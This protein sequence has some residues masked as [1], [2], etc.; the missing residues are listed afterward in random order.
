MYVSKYKKYK[1]KYLSLRK[2]QNQ[3]GGNKNFIVTINIKNNLHVKNVYTTDYQCETN[4]NLSMTEFYDAIKN[5][6]ISENIDAIDFF[7]EHQ[8][9]QTSFKSLYGDSFF[10]N[11]D[12]FKSTV[13]S[14]HSGTINIMVRPP[15]GLPFEVVG[16]IIHYIL[17]QLDRTK[18]NQMLFVPFS[19]NVEIVTS[20]RLSTTIINKN[21][22]QGLDL[23]MLFN[24]PTSGVY[25]LIL[26]DQFFE[27]NNQQTYDYLNMQKNI[28]DPAKIFR[29]NVQ[30][31]CTITK[32]IFNENSLSEI[33]KK[34]LDDKVN[35]IHNNYI[36]NIIKK[37]KVEKSIDAPNENIIDLIFNNKTFQ[38]YTIAARITT[39]IDLDWKLFLEAMLNHYNV[40]K[41]LTT[42]YT[43][44]FVSI[45]NDE[46]KFPHFS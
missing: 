33:K 27:D 44:S 39:E 3:I 21:I 31:N 14:N 8:Y 16:D 5:K 45:N 34:L 36:N 11:D 46:I 1:S 30:N 29:E 12:S 22:H 32:Y 37:Y 26:M 10:Y 2:I 9:L 42:F 19:A 17:T 41:N 23:N 18:I 13:N 24:V 20:E 43:R 35:L 15:P 7:K 38:L 40:S 25:T 28:I 6:I 4:F